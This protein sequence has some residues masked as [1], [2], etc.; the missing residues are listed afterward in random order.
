MGLKNTNEN[1]DKLIEMASECNSYN[2]SCEWVQAYSFDEIDDILTGMEPSE[3]LMKVFFGKVDEGIGYDTARIRFNGYENIEI[4]SVYE[5][6]QDA[7]DYR[8]EIFENYKDAVSESEYE[9]AMEELEFEE[10]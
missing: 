1:I 9:R 5:L 6:E 3:I 8:E 4:I 7:W 2:G 10:D